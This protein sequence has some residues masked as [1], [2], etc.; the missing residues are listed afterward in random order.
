MLLLQISIQSHPPQLCLLR[1]QSSVFTE[2]TVFTLPTTSSGGGK[3]PG[4]NIANTPLYYFHKSDTKARLFSS[5][6]NTIILSSVH[7]WISSTIRYDSLLSRSRVGGNPIRQDHD[8]HT[9]FLLRRQVLLKS[10]LHHFKSPRV[11][12]LDMRP[13]S[14]KISQL[15]WLI[16]TCLETN[17][18]NHDT[19]LG[20]EIDY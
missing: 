18:C 16:K 5:R 13:N 17:L 7:K 3:R 15:S 1:R 14:S 11:D 6:H 19:P 8:I 10:R 12:R 4:L 20:A 2:D 9:S